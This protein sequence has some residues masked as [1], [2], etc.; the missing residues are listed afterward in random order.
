MNDFLNI[1]I[2]KLR[3]D[4][5]DLDPEEYKSEVRVF[6]CSESDI[7][8]MSFDCVVRMFKARLRT[9]IGTDS[10]FCSSNSGCY[11]HYLKFDIEVDAEELQIIVNLRLKKTARL[12]A[13]RNNNSV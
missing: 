2:D 4:T 13:R 5:Y 3:L 6:E 1:C 11:C 8:T 9:E 7:G 10:D 12:L